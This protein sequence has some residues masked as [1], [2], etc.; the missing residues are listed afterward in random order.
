MQQ[1]KGTYLG[2]IDFLKGLAIVF[3]ILLHA[4]PRSVLEDTWALLHIWQA[5]PL[6]IFV[7]FVL[8][9]MKLG[10]ITLG[11]YYNKHNLLKLFKRIVVPFLAIEGLLLILFLIKGDNEHIGQFLQNWRIGRG[12]YYFYVYLQIWLFA[13]F[14]YLVLRWNQIV[15]G[16]FLLLVSLLGNIICHKA[17]ISPMLE[18]CLAVRYIFI[19]VIAYQWLNNK[20]SVLWKFVFPAISI[21]YWLSMSK[22]DLTP[23]IPNTG[24]WGGQQFPA[25]FYLFPFVS[26]LVYLYSKC[27]KRLSSLIQWLGKYSWEI[28]LMQ[29]VYFLLP[30]NQLIPITNSVVHLIS[31]SVI[32]MALCILPVYLYSKMKCIVTK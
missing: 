13:P 32:S 20:E 25:Y 1:D 7:S 15:G 6:F 12:S 17:D 31:Y 2:Y 27:T 16:V 23:Y 22:H 3:V 5:V 4:F 30:V 26:M 28:F 11:V 14:A 24:G 10:R 9:Y 18:S 21:A 29:M 19:A 8:I